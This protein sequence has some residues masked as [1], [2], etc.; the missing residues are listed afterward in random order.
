MTSRE[1]T[2]TALRGGQPDRVPIQLFGS[3]GCSVAMEGY[4]ENFRR[5]LSYARQNADM[6][7]GWHAPLGQCYAGM[8]S[9]VE[10][11]KRIEKEGEVTLTKRIIET[12]RGPITQVSESD[13]DTTSD[14]KLRKHFIES[15]DDFEKLMSI[16]FSPYRP[17]L[18][19]Y[20]DLRK[21]VGETGVV[22]VFLTGPVDVA[23]LFFSPT[24]FVLWTVEEKDRLHA[25]LRKIRSHMDDYLDYLLE[26]RVG[27]VFWF[28]GAEQVVPPL[29]PPAFFDAYV[30]FYEKPLID[31]I[32]AAGG[33]A[34]LHCHGSV[35]RVLRQI[36][37]TGYDALQPVEAPPMGDI[38][39][40]EAREMT[41]GNIALVGNIQVGE[42]YRSTPEKIDA[43]CREAIEQ[44]KPGGGFILGITSSYYSSSMDDRTLANYIAY[45]DAGRKYGDYH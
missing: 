17:D 31:K 42:M 1:R 26:N 2:L 25:L 20:F 3:T 35:K 21:I 23:A 10:I 13:A 33:L 28:G 12:P 44:G 9:G 11:Q 29:G 18:G 5:L 22:S 37:A 24:E 30:S 27:E 15:E 19:G 36:V 40:A 43:L 32:H 38:T 34:I 14:Y 41:E 45:I 39:L 16:Q 8:Y 7:H 6:M 4:G